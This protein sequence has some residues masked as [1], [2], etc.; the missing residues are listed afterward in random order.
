MSP[1][2]I[3]GDVP[4]SPRVTASVFVCVAS[5]S[6]MASWDALPHIISC[7]VL[8]LPEEGLT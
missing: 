2:V 7:V 4:P 6:L 3:A 5:E 1:V 8:G